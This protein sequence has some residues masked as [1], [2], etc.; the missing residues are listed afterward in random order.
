MA[1]VMVM[2]VLVMRIGNGVKL[3][4]MGEDDIGNTRLARP[5]HVALPLARCR[6]VCIHPPQHTWLISIATPAL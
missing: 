6:P 4:V 5:V 2:M 3:M 1:I